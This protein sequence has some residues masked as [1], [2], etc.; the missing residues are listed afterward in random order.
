[1][2]ER[3]ERSAEITVRDIIKGKAGE[4]ALIITNPDTESYNISLALFR[5]FQ[6]IQV[7]PVI[8]VQPVKTQFDYAEP[9]VISALKSEPEIILSISK[10][11]MGKDKAAIE[12][13]YMLDGKEIDN[14]FHYLLQTGKSRSFWSPGIT[15][16]MFIRTVPIS[17][18]QLKA[19]CIRLKVLLDRAD[20][21]HISAPGGTDLD[22]GLRGRKGFED[23]GDFSAPG[24]G[25]NVPAG[26]VFISPELGTANG[27]IVF[28]GSI[29]VRSGDIVIHEPIRVQVENGFAVSIN[30]NE[31][32]DAAVLED[33]IT[34][35]ERQ[36]VRMETEGRLPAGLGTVYAKNARNLGE[37]GIGLNPAAE[38][39]GNMLEDEKAFR[40]CHIAIGCNY[41][42]DA[43]ALIHLD[44]L[45]RNPTIE[46]FNPDGTSVMIMKDGIIS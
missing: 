32:A 36:A 39:T 33:T 11:K 8:A 37:V 3:L 15:E 26:E 5:A 24:A 20:R 35:G 34:C 43:P 38:I 10:N 6:N 44:G 2:D 46:L 42:E 16:D 41:D 31:S 25:G 1:M 9:A 40:T 28:D 17:Y 14:T 7:A 13:P 27:T 45:V 23:N 29:S 22:V 30:S 19:D 21:M 18:S 12:K 4:R